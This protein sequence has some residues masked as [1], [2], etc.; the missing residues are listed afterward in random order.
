LIVVI[1]GTS[2][3]FDGHGHFYAMNGFVRYLDGLAEEFG[4]VHLFAISETVKNSARTS[5]DNQKIILHPMVRPENQT[6]RFIY[7]LRYMLI[8]IKT[9]I[10]SQGII[11]SFPASG[12]IMSEIFLVLLSKCYVVYY[13]NDP[14]AIWNTKNKNSLLGIIKN[15]YIKQSSVKINHLAK[16]ILVRDTMQF[17]K[18]LAR[19][20]SKT[21]L[22][23]AK[24]NFWKPLVSSRVYK[25]QKKVKLLYV[26]KLEISKGI[27]E[28]LESFFCL[29]EDSEL[30]SKEFYLD[31]IGGGE[32]DIEFVKELISLN[33][34]QYRLSPFNNISSRINLLGYIDDVDKLA[35]CFLE[36]DIFV[37]P[38][39]FEGFPRV[40]DEASSFGLPIVCT[41]LPS[42]CAVMKDNIHAIFTPPYDSCSIVAG[43]KKL[44]LDPVLYEAM[45]KN[46]I[47]LANGR[48][49][50]TPVEQHARLIK[51]FIN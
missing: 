13:K 26:G 38:S 25:M 39:Y 11:E 23:V 3:E 16:I 51:D 31:I 1:G 37:F 45:G 17:K 9:S 28:L 36:S 6:L 19:F 14:V 15:F 30:S 33:K 32:D 8:M 29:Y 21:H 50:E 22:S 46:L 49:T 18:L 24:S 2:I 4:E 27:K 43:I 10:G 41:S 20:P 44:I 7:W 42:I 5:I 48:T 35:T 40:I 34:R 47:T 12:G